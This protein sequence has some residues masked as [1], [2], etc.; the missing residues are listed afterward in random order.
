MAEG[1]RSNDI[2]RVVDW[3][4]ARLWHSGHAKHVS[5]G[6]QSFEAG[7]DSELGELAGKLSWVVTQW[8]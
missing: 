4:D 8:D 3:G 1:A 2:G 6:Y 5:Q 7:I